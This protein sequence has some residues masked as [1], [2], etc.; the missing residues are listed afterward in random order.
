MNNIIRNDPISAYRRTYRVVDG[1]TE[2]NETTINIY[3]VCQDI[4]QKKLASAK[5]GEIGK[6]RKEYVC[7]VSG[8]YAD[9]VVRQAFEEFDYTIEEVSY[10]IQRPTLLLGRL[11]HLASRDN[12]IGFFVQTNDIQD[13]YVALLV[14][15]Q[16]IYLLDSL[17][18]APRLIKRLVELDTIGLIWAIFDNDPNRTEPE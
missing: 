13:H 3:S 8:D 1:R 17:E 14:R 2:E 7:R 10:F 6:I 9:E 16:K 18:P 12:F 4:L 5:R 11:L 15:N